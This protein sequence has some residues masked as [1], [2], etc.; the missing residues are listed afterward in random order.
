MDAEFACLIVTSRYH[1]P[2]VR[3]STHGKRLAG[4]CRVVTCFYRGIEAV[5]IAVD[6]LSWGRHM[7]DVAGEFHSKLQ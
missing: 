7:R 5:A 1:T 4:Q 3:P 6:D 2:F